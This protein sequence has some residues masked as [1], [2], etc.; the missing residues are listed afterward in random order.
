MRPQ[1]S[2]VWLGTGVL[3]SLGASICCLLPLGLVVLGLGG[4]WMAT[5]R[6]FDPYRPLLIAV[7]LCALVLAYWRISWE[8]KVCGPGNACAE[9]AVVRRRKL[10][11][12]VI[13]FVAVGLIASPY[14][15]ALFV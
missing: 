12:W 7:A 10:I 2:T 1:S 13:V 11:F 8:A 14:G 3:A 5:L 15:I 6:V 4:S 9:P